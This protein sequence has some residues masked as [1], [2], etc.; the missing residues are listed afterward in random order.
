M[1]SNK[2]IKKSL[3]YRNLMR[4][5]KKQPNKDR[6]NIDDCILQYICYLDEKVSLLNEQLKIQDQISCNQQKQIML[7]QKQIDILRK[8]VF[9]GDTDGPNGDPVDTGEGDTDGVV[10]TAGNDDDR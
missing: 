4:A 3:G 8:A 10:S 5:I 2:L 1:A 7:Q 6:T 9:G